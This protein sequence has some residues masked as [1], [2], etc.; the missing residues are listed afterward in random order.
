YPVGPVTVTGNHALTAAE[1]EPIFHHLDY[2]KVWTGPVPF[3]VRQLRDDIGKLTLRY[4]GLGYPGAR[5]SSTFDPARSDDRKDKNV[6]IVLQVN[7]R[8][9]ITVSFEGNRRS[10]STLRDQLTMDDRGS[11]DD[12]EVGNSADALQ[13]YYQ[14]HGHFFARVA[15]RRERLSEDEER[16][17]F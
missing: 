16:I 5:V 15:W 7:E 4:R 8:K 3:T 2:H 6:A 9:R 1:I 14:D 10:A 13:R 11:Y 12:Y 17:V